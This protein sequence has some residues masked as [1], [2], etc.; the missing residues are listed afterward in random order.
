VFDAHVSIEKA[1]PERYDRDI[2]RYDCSGVLA[3]DASAGLDSIGNVVMNNPQ[4][5]H[6]AGASVAQVERIF[7]SDFNR[8]RRQFAFPIAFQ[9]QR[10]GQDHLVRV[11]N[12]EEVR[13]FFTGSFVAAHHQQ[14][15]KRAKSEAQDSPAARAEAAAVAQ[16]V[17]NSPPAAQPGADGGA[18]N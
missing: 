2:Y 12:I 9:S 7:L 17:S 4:M 11:A 5:L 18:K 14:A 8:A 1:T 6:N 13:L 15:L 10:A 16:S 3:I